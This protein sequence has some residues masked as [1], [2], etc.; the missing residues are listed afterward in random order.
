MNLG[1]RYSLLLL[2]TAISGAAQVGLHDPQT[3]LAGKKQFEAHCAGC[4]G[5]DGKGG[6]HGP[7]IVEARY[8][9]TRLPEGFREIIRNGIPDFGMP[10]FQLPDEVLQQLVAF[11]VSM[12]APAMDSAVEGDVKAGE[13]F[14]FGKGNCSNCHMIQ[15]RGGFIGPDLTSIARERKLSEIE[16]TLHNPSVYATP[17]YQVVSVHLRDG[18]TVRGLAKNETIYDLQL[19]TL[20]GQLYLLRRDDIMSESHEPKSLMPTVEASKEEL[21]NLLAYLCQLSGPKAGASE[22]TEKIGTGVSFSDLVDPTPGEWPSYHGRLSGNRY[23]PLK[24]I[25]ADNLS[26]LAPKWLFSIPNSHHL[27]VTPVVA[28]GVMYVTAA[29]EAY[30]VDPVNGRQIWHY[31]RPLTKGVI[32]DAAEGINRGVALLGD[33]VF[34][35]TDN[36]HLIALHRSNGQL[37]WDVEMADYRKGYGATSAPLIVKDLVISGTS[38]GDEGVRGFVAAYKASTGER[39]WRF[40]TMPAR[41]EP[42]SETWVGKAIEH[43]C[44][45]AWLTGTYDPELDL[46]YWTTG[47]PCPDFNGDERK[48]DNLYSSSVLALKP[49]TGKLQ[50]YFQ[51]SPHDVHDWDATQV[52]MLIDAD[53]HGRPRKLLALG[54]RN[55]FFYVLDRTNGE[56]LLGQPF[57]HKLTWATGIGPEGRPKIAPGSEPTIEGVR[58]CPAVSGA[59]NWMSTAYNPNT[60]LFY[61]MVMEKCEIHTKSSALWEPG[62]S[63]M[64]GGN[65]DIPG[66]PG[67]K[68]LRAL[69]L[70]TGRIVWECPQIGRSVTYGGVLSTAGGLVFFGEDSGAFTALDA[71]T[72]QVLWYFQTN[73]VWGASP[74]TYMAKGKQYIAIAAGSNIIAFGLH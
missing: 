69:E 35:V 52:P 74:M 2:S 8:P 55:G 13:K 9:R 53:F 22:S 43:G 59:T 68:F 26:A 20:D 42:L 46:L 37:V 51:F 23:S 28:E 71:Y 49:E 70:Q 67:Q 66:E 1:L 40:W 30:A 47:N 31:A 50:W 39:V 36:A 60:G 63:F 5:V 19:Q 21:Q 24:Q 57:V 29:N 6:E 17:G 32:G 56:F 11:V 61:L 65:R 41:G 14:F 72:G 58:V 45:T 64:G 25:D 44:S 27:E 38:G 48:G 33:R 3:I 34:M 7:N 4:H 54:N 18:R 10:A 12:T 62:Q 73:Q 16:Q 15:G